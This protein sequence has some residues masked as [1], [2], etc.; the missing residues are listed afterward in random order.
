M[1]RE[2]RLSGLALVY[3]IAPARPLRC[4]EGDKD[5]RRTSTSIRI[6]HVLERK[7]SRN[8]TGD[9]PVGRFTIRWPFWRGKRRKRDRGA[10]RYGRAKNSARLT[11]R[12]Q[13]PA[14][15]PVLTRGME[16]DLAQNAGSSGTHRLCLI[17]NG[18]TKFIER[19]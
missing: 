13:R 15:A 19:L 11:R 12:L 7:A 10:Q 3:S 4:A 5:A 17:R 14:P 1:V 18:Q 6:L 8:W 9:I 16:L 2:L